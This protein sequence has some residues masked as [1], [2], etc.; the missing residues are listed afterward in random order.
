MQKID[1]CTEIRLT[2]TRAGIDAR[3]EKCLHTF[4]LVVTAQYI[5]HSGS[6][7]IR[8]PPSLRHASSSHHQVQDQARRERP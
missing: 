4:R 3:P 7:A 8:I 6:V 2:P 1:D 5:Y